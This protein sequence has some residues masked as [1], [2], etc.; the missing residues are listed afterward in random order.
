ME[1]TYQGIGT[2]YFDAMRLQ[3]KTLNEYNPKIK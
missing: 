3:I 1:M 2:R